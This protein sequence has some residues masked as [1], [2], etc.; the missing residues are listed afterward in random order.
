[1]SAVA[2][3]FNRVKSSE[4]IRRL[5]IA[6]LERFSQR[7]KNTYGCWRWYG[8]INQAGYG[9]FSV[10]N[11]EKGS[12][13]ILAHRIMYEVYN[14]YHPYGH[15]DHLCRNTRCVRPDHL[16]LVSPRENTRRGVGPAAINA[17]KTHCPWGHPYSGDNLY[18]GKNANSPNRI[19]RQCRAC[20]RVGSLRSVTA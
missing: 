20:R 14:G 6:D 3:T 8:A 19:Y 2:E 9:V 7:Y 5:T 4:Y 16:E 10:R 12:Y 18:T 13:P 1:M 11:E 17:K 15:V